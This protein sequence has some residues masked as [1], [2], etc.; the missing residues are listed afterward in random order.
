MQR[1]R[2]KPCVKR[3]RSLIITKVETTLTRRNVGYS[4]KEDVGY[5]GGGREKRVGLEG[6]GK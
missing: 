1:Q 4:T 6:D 5:L 2:E 3:N